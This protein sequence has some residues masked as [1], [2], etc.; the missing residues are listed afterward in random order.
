MPERLTAQEIL[1]KKYPPLFRLSARIAEIGKDAEPYV[2]EQ[3]YSWPFADQQNPSAL[4]LPGV[5]T[6]SGLVKYAEAAE[7]AEQILQIK[8]E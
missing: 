4:T 2:G 1:G 3:G 5:L 7:R 8:G 6:K